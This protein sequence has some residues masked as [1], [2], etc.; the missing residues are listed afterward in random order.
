MI[1]NTFHFMFNGDVWTELNTLCLKSCRLKSCADKI[2]VYCGTPGSG[3]DWVAAQCIPGIVWN[4]AHFPCTL[5]GHIVSNKDIM[6]QYHGLYKLYLFGGFLC[7][8]NFIFLKSFEEFRHNPVVIGLNCK[9]KKKLSSDM[10]GAIPESPF[11]KSL[12][13]TYKGVN[14][15][16]E[17]NWTK[18][19]AND[20]WMLALQHTVT[21]LPRPTLFPWCS[22]NKQFVNG[23][24]VLFKKSHAFRIWNNTP[25]EVLRKTCLGPTIKEIES[26]HSSS[27]VSVKEGILFT[28]D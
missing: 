17:S 24:P 26:G 15:A 22:S 6:R 2:I 18:A 21:I 7:D 13:D 8:L 9:A 20:S 27:N 12:L 1:P 23:K 19:S 14:P 11:I 25:V 4:Y 16:T 5:N 10:I 3:Q 28:F